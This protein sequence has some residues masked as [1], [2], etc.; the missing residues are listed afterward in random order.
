LRVERF[1][2]ENPLRVPLKGERFRVEHSLRVP[3][4]VERFRGE[5]LL[6]GE[7]SGDYPSST[8]QP[9]NSSTPKRPFGN[10]R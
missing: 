1:R 5:N 9:L 8:P 7:R 6:R 2:V 10:D 4:R 3:L